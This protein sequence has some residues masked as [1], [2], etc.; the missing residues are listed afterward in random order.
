MRPLVTVGWPAGGAYPGISETKQGRWDEV[1][2]F[3]L[4]VEG[5]RGLGR[6]GYRV[7]GSSIGSKVEGRQ[8]LGQ[9]AAR[10]RGKIK[11]EKGT[12]METIDRAW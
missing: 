4:G 5:F 6:R 2:G 7:Y 8:G 10:A 11:E 1:Q 9:K 3:G 12:T